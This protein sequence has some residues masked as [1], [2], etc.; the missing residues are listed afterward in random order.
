M[1]NKYKQS[2]KGP[3]ENVGKVIRLD[4]SDRDF[5]NLFKEMYP[6]MWEDLNKKYDFW[7]YKNNDLIRKGKKSRYNFRN[8]TNF[9]LDC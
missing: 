2:F 4:F 8:P 9:V 5:I 1:Y 7:H 3:L 6:Y